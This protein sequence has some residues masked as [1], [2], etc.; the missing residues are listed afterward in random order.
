MQNKSKLYVEILLGSSIA[1]LALSYYFRGDVNTEEFGLGENTSSHYA[2]SNNNSIHLD[3]ISFAELNDVDAGC[4]QRGNKN[5]I[6]ILG[7]SQTHG[8]NKFE[9]NQKT[10]N[11]L[12]LLRL[13]DSYDVITHS[14]PNAN[15]Q[16]FYLSY[17]FW[18]SSHKI[19]YLLMPVFFDD[20]RDDGI[21]DVFF[22]Y[23]N[24]Y[25]FTISD[26]NEI[27][28]KINQALK[29]QL[30]H[31][32]KDDP[33]MNALKQTVQE[34]V[35]IE[36]NNFVE[37]KSAT[38][39][40]RPSIRG[41]L[42]IQ[43]YLLRNSLLGIDAQTKRKIIPNRYVDNMKALDAILKLAQKNN[44]KVLLYIPP[45][46]SDVEI[47]YDRD[48]YKAFKTE[49]SKL[50]ASFANV[51]YVNLENIIPGKY[52]GLKASTNTSG[53]PEYDFMHFQYAGHQILDS[54]LFSNLK[55][56]LK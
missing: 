55:P 13:K 25:P 40:N 42:F 19:D 53:K 9:P 16:E 11:E 49:L 5:E 18:Q 29:A 24:E 27:A 8:I 38:W 15:L 44:T 3:K 10:Y 50:P 4:T 12:L 43:L 37:S 47:P 48:D 20:L 17:Y 32:V 23:F 2:K 46:R 7:N 36:L 45:I 30:K 34:S 22:P 39:A 41:E 28:I 6:Y 33:N 35:E 54:A 1:I 52:W 56:L 21:R 26:S 31:A 51:T 14:L